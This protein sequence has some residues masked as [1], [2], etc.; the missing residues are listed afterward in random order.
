MPSM[1]FTPLLL[2]I[3]TPLC[4]WCQ[5]L[6]LIPKPQQVTIQ[7]GYLVV[8]DIQ[9]RI[10]IKVESE[11]IKQGI[12]MFK[13]IAELEAKQ[14]LISNP[15]AIHIRLAND[16]ALSTEGYHLRLS[17]DSITLE[18]NTVKGIFYGNETLEQILRPNTGTDI[19]LYD[20][21][22]YPTYA[23]R[24]MHLDV[25][26]HF[27]SKEMIKQYIDLLAKYKINT[28]HWHLT[29]D[30]GWRIEIQKYPKL[31]SVGAW[32]TEKDGKKYGGYYSQR[33]IEDIVAYA[34]ERFVTIVPELE[35]PGH[36]SAALAAYPEFGCTGRALTVPNTWGIKP[37]IYAPTDFVLHFWEDVMDEVCTLFPGKY[38]HIGG[39]EAPKGQWKKS[40]T[41]QDVM[42]EQQLKNEEELQYYFMHRVEQYLHKKGRIAIGWGEVVKGGLSDS[43]VV[44]S[45]LSK[46]AGIKAAKS[47]NDAIM[48]PRAYCYFDYPQHS[49]DKMKAIW[50]LPLPLKKVYAFDPMPKGLS[51]AAQKHVIGG[52]A[53]LWTEY[54]STEKQLMYQLMPRLCA[55]SEALWTKPQ[56]KNF[57]DFESRVKTL[58]K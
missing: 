3:L 58:V 1:K 4:A 38:I 5:T 41:A 36:S 50:M 51:D 24:G 10:R 47:G 48:A 44:M 42:K 27:F 13:S 35:M 43:I 21:I 34:Q 56:L 55:M 2:I 30:Q 16:K 31:T 54:V 46:Q 29:D 8:K 26:R 19:P 6:N 39:D 52:E 28:F 20:I 7:P 33:D 18:A 25:C 45:W 15:F 53:T 40:P 14:P 22:D 57:D 49:K 12:P 17:K 11:E 37:D 9:D 23:Y 32:R